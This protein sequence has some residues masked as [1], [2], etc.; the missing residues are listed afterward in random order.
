M[1]IFALF[2]FV[3]L[4][5][6]GG[7]SINVARNEFSRIRLQATTDAAI[8][9][10]ADLDQTLDPK[11]VV[12]DYFAKAGLADKLD[13]DNIVVTELINSR[14]VTATAKYDQPNMLFNIRLNGISDRLPQTFPV[15]AAG[16]AKEEISDIEVS[17]VLDVS[18]SMQY[19]DRME[20][21]RKA[22]KDFAEEVLS[23]DDGAQSGLSEV[24]LSI[25]PYSTQAAAPQPIL[26]AMNLGHRHDYSGCVDFEADDFTTTK[27]PIPTEG[28]EDDPL[29]A[30][31]RAQTAHVDP[32]YSETEKDPRFR[33]CRTDAAFRSTALGGSVSQVQGDIQALTQGGS[34]SIDVG[35]KW[36]VSLLDPSIR[37]VVS[38]MIDAG[39]I[40]GDFEGRPYD[41][42]RPNAM[43]VLVVMTDGKNEEQWQI[44]DAYASGPSDVFTYWDG[45]KT[46]YAVDAPEETHSFYDWRDGRTQRH[47]DDDYIG[48]ERFYLPHDDTWENLE[49]K[50]LTRLDWK[51]VWTA[52]RV[53]YHANEFREDQ[54]GSQSAY[55]YWTGSDVVTEIDRTE[56]D[57][58]MENICQAAKDEGIVIFAVG[59]K[60]D[61]TYAKKL[62]DCV[63][64]DNNYFDVDNDEI[65]YAFA[66]IASAINQLRLV[67]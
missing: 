60:I 55:D 27:L 17:L 62:R 12:Q 43:K 54:Y 4:C 24:S 51:D 34:T 21:M 13:P 25:V 37:D 39:Q 8:L 38:D 16:S 6:L 31:R 26:D 52:M 67:K 50:D 36:G 30:T 58:R 47:G 3:C 64:N 41:Y 11:S 28:H 44:T 19:Y 63:G 61:S 45:Y 35:I 42:D 20:N 40:S 15:A 18:G 29:D 48:N 10:A 49:D 65:D 59:V 32:Y 66:A 14:Q 23:A 7:L 2:I 22:A 53:K 57:T 56:K 9:A 5:L 46:R 33:V 1:L